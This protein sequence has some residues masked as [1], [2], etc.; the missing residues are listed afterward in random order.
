MQQLTNLIRILHSNIFFKRQPFLLERSSYL[1]VFQANVVKWFFH[2][3]LLCTRSENIQFCLLEKLANLFYFHVKSI[4]NCA[5]NVKCMRVSLNWPAERLQIISLFSLRND[6]CCL[7]LLAYPKISNLHPARFTAHW[8]IRAHRFI[9]AYWWI[10][11]HWCFHAH[12]YMYFH[13]P[14]H[15][16][17][18]C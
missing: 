1:I 18:L 8:Q 4:R 9:H 7:N 5:Y 10:Y 17:A 12:W 2:V 15:I 11:A 13:A 14:S 3:D 16:T 6:V